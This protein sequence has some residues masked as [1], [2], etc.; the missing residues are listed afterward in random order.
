MRKWCG[1]TLIEL[2]VVVAIIA[3]LISILVPSLKA[4]KEAAK[5]VI[6]QSQ[7]RQIG[8]AMIMYQGDNKGKLKPSPQPWPNEDDFWWRD[9]AIYYGPYLKTNYELYEDWALEVFWCPSFDPVWAPGPKTGPTG[10]P[11]VPGWATWNTSYWYGDVAAG[12]QQKNPPEPYPPKAFK[13]SAGQ[14][15][16]V[17]R[18]DY[19]FHQGKTT[20]NLLYID[21]HVEPYDISEPGWPPP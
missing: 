20:M 2:L 3:V 4:A 18:E 7:M 5:D 1:F 15:R 6:C 17:L 14:P 13:N 21:G 19:Y 10:P 9:W 11:D 12:N 16:H 8:V